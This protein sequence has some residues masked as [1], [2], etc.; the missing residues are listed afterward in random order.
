M[1]GTKPAFYRK[2]NKRMMTVNKSSLK[3]MWLG[4][5]ANFSF[6]EFYYFT[7]KITTMKQDY[8]ETTLLYIKI[9]KQT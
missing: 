4:I 7:L 5:N 8:L 1:I 9:Q 6:F 2:K 3:D